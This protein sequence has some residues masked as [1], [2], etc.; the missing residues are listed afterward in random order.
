MW[1][2]TNR[3]K[4]IVTIL[5]NHG[6]TSENKYSSSRNHF[7]KSNF[8][9]MSTSGDMS[10]YL[11]ESGYIGTAGIGEDFYDSGLTEERFEDQLMENEMK[12]RMM[13]E[14]SRNLEVDLSSLGLDEQADV[15][16]PISKS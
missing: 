14:S 13:M 15:C 3:H 11:N 9:Y 10:S 6:A 4:E 12:R 2:M 5:R 8:D 16:L 1:A 7:E